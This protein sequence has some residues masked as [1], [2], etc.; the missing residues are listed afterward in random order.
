MENKKEAC[1]VAQLPEVFK[2][3]MQK[4]LGDDY[5]SF[6]AAYDKPYRNAF[7]L[8][9]LKCDRVPFTKADGACDG[10][11]NADGDSDCGFAPVP[12]CAAGYYYDE[13]LRPGKHPY[14]DAG[15]YYIQE[16][17]AMS[18]AELA[19]VRP[20]QKVLDLCAAPGGKTTALA[21]SLCGEGLLVANEIHPSRARILSQNVERMGITNCIV[22]NE[23]PEKLVSRFSGFF[24]T[25]VVDAPCSG[26]GMFRK[27]PAAITCWSLENIRLC[28]ERQKE[29][30]SSAVAM[31]SP[32]GRLI[33]STCTFAPEE[34]EEIVAF[35]EEE[36]GLNC[37]FS[38]KFWPHKAD[39]EGHFVAVMR[40]VR[41]GA[42]IVGD[43]PA[44]PVPN[45]K[46][47]ALDEFLQKDFLD[48][49]LEGYK[50]EFGDNI[51]ICPMENPEKVLRGLKVLRPGLQIGSITKGRFIPSH[52]LALSL[53]KEDAL[54][55]VNL[56]VETAKKFIEGLSLQLD[57][58][59]IS[60]AGYKGWVL[61]LVD[62]Y[63]LGWGKLSGGTL[64]NHYPKGLR[65]Q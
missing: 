38:K 30:L 33:Y 17:S 2:E 4:F 31:L 54:C 18:V 22:T 6:I 39:G 62:G 26:E 50:L 9:T 15:L 8:N 44:L 7:R 56:D 57:P 40:D 63:S 10:A 24:D 41:N 45:L 65:H 1:F 5:E 34:D 48:K 21:A 35:L 36:H 55:A 61:V 16:P 46:A 23:S 43:A 28:S 53:K 13:T 47:L 25:I 58:A 19:D 14:H 12:W 29:I 51:Y 52:A 37:E 32:G 60:P 42:A 3:R 49:K 20:G 64:K 59:D 11:V 27:E